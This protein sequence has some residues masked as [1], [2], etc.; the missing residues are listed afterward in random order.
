M[1]ADCLALLYHAASETQADLTTCGFTYVNDHGETMGTWLPTKQERVNDYCED[2][3]K[4]YGINTLCNKMLV[5]SCVKT[6]F[7]TQHSM[8]EDLKFVCDYLGDVQKITIIE[9]PLYTYYSE[10]AGSLTKNSRL[11]M[12]AIMYDIRNMAALA[13]TRQ[14]SMCLVVNRFFEQIW[15]ILFACQSKFDLGVTLEALLLM[16]GLKDFSKEN[17]PSGL[18]CH[19]IRI[20]L[21]NRCTSILYA[22]AELKRHLDDIIHRVKGLVHEEQKIVGV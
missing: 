4:R 13:Y 10:N 3:I 18:K 20:L 15:L 2:W 1:D 14:I 17:I 11:R 21:N 8:G 16:E 6:R 9:R 5:R 19:L 12:E 7:D 22:V